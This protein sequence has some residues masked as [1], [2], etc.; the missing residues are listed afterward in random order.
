LKR[1]DSVGD[2]ATRAC[3]LV[4]K[5]LYAV[6]AAMAALDIM[7]PN[8]YKSEELKNEA[9]EVSELVKTQLDSLFS[10]I[11]NPQYGL[12]HPLGCQIMQNASDEFKGLAEK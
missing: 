8:R 2:P 5:L 4:D 6:D 10:W 9:K 3:M 12:S 7:M 11:Q 1:I